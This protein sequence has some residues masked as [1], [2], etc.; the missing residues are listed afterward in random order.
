MILKKSKTKVL[1][2]GEILPR[3]TGCTLTIDYPTIE[4]MESIRGLGFE[5]IYTDSEDKEI[6][7]TPEK[8]SRLLIISEQIAKFYMKYCI[9]DWNGFLGEDEQPIKFELINNA[10]SPKLFNQF[11]YN[12]TYEE[13][14]KIGTAIQSQVEFSEADKKK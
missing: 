14:I 3:F 1:D 6:E 9:K 7:K 2:L 4:Q 8:Q 5:M 11:V 13:M 12:L 10:M